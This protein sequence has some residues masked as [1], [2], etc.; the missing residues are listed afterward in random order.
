[1]HPKEII[2]G[3]VEKFSEVLQVWFSMENCQSLMIG[4]VK[5]VWWFFHQTESSIVDGSRMLENGRSKLL[6]SWLSIVDI[7][8]RAWSSLADRWLGLLMILRST[9]HIYRLLW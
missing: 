1:M 4:L 2:D 7:H 8:P 6:S 3:Q 9:T 5:L